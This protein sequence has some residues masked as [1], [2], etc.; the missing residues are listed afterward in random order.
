MAD[1]Q[2]VSAPSASLDDLKSA[3]LC[4]RFAIMFAPCSIAVGFDNQTLRCLPIDPELCTHEQAHTDKAKVPRDNIARACFS[5]T[6]PTAVLD[7]ILV[8]FSRSA[9]ELM[10][11]PPEEAA[12]PEFVHYF[13]GCKVIPG[14]Q[15]AAHTYC[16][17][18]FGNFSGQLGDGA[19]MYLGEVEN[20][21]T[22]LRWEIQLKGA[23]MTPYSRRADGR[24]VLRS[25]IRE[26][27]C[28]EAMHFLGVPT[29]RAGSCITSSTRV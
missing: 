17:Y 15:P 7:P 19:T 1:L 16:G 9:L 27:L 4:L 25:S 6:W 20:L 8:S 23:G 24:K 5:L 2:D 28:S 21:K 26:Y 22:N 3:T 29:T 13:S 18:Q 12:R 14:A 11:L 10:D